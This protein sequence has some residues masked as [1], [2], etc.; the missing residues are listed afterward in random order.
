MV[1]CSAE[2]LDT[3]SPAADLYT[4]SMFRIAWSAATAEAEAS[5][6]R[7]LILSALHGLLDPATLVAPY[8][9]KL[10]DDRSIEADELAAQIADTGIIAEADDVYAFLPNGYLDLLDSALRSLDFTPPAP[11]FEA[12]CGIGEH[13]K[14]CRIVRDTNPN[15]M[16]EVAA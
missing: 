7:V 15:P 11:V 12:T 4:G 14:V 6:G 1:A 5:G 3:T 16:T 13:R 10:G 9:C 8:D 2:K